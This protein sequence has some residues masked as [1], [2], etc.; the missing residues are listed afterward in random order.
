[1]I[2]LDKAR[3]LNLI[4][5]RLVSNNSSKNPTRKELL[6]VLRSIRYLQIDPTSVVCKSQFLVLWSRLGNYD[7]RILDDMLWKDRSLFE[8]WAHGASIALTE[9][10]P[11]FKLG[12]KIATNNLTPYQKRVQDFV[13]ANK[14]LSDHIKGELSSRGPLVSSE[15]EDKSEERWRSTGWSNERNVGKMLEIMHRRGEV[16]VH[17]RSNGGQKKWDLAA[18]YYASFPQR[19]LNDHEITRK[20]LEISLKAMGVATMLQ[21]RD[22]FQPGRRP[23][24]EVLKAIN[25]MEGEGLIVPV[26]I[27]NIPTRRTGRWFVHSEDMKILADLGKH[28]RPKTTLLSPF[29]NLIYDRVRTNY[30]FGFSAIF[31]AYVPKEKRIYGYYVLPILHGDKLVGRVDP[32][33]DRKNRV[34]RINSIHLE[35]GVGGSKDLLNP[36]RNTIRDLARF[37]GAEKI[38]TGENVET[39]WKKELTMAA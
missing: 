34:F 21:M 10:Y 18:K 13:E 39:R 36:I 16:V 26:E 9:D 32:E 17:S 25:E 8:Y 11:L 23:A 38:A 7:V 29:D 20:G 4:K 3:R 28:W 12:M 6:S 30:L 35:K 5:Q 31:E 1:V 24:S 37:L 22:Y 33:M 15:I 27:E 2:S 19:D 14:E